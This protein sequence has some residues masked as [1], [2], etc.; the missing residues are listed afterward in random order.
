MHFNTKVGFNR[1]VSNLDKEGV[2]RFSAE[3]WDV[4]YEKVVGYAPGEVH[5]DNDSAILVQEGYHEI[6]RIMDEK[7]AEKE[8]YDEYQRQ[9]GIMGMASMPGD[10]DD[11]E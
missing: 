5:L 8:R 1:L 4:D 11:S 9:L 10:G 3:P 6:K 7:E 2:R